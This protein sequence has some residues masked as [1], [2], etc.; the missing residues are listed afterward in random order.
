MDLGQLD[1]VADSRIR[2]VLSRYAVIQDLATFN[3]SAC[4]ITSNGWSP[5]FLLAGYLK[6]WHVPLEFFTG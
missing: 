3:R 6:R 5:L 1:A 2:K 4:S